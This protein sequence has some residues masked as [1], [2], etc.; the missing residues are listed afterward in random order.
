M[1]EI[2]SLGGVKRLYAVKYET[3]WALINFSRILAIV[4]TTEIGL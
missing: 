3:I 4:M 1:F 2:G